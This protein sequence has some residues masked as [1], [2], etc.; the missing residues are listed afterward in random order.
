MNW[1]AA[2][3]KSRHEFLTNK[4]LHKKGIETFLPFIQKLSQWKDRKKAVHFPLFPGYLFVYVCPNPQNFLN[5]LRTRG[6]VTLVSLESNYPTAISD[7]EV[8]S[9]KILIENGDDFD[10]YPHLQEGTPIR[11]RQGPL[12]GAEGFLTKKKDKNMFF[13]NV[14]L[15]GRSLG[16]EIYADDIE[17]A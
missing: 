1:F 13:V 3:V 15:L 8:N 11:I 12:K 4:E 7:E 16:L 5:V 10:I 14:N 9:L 2:Y 6:V 17:A